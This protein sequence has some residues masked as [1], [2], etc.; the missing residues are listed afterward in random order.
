MT[1]FA[2]KRLDSYSIRSVNLCVDC[3]ISFTCNLN[4][5]I[6]I[7]KFWKVSLFFF[8]FLNGAIVITVE[9]GSIYHNSSLEKNFEASLYSYL[10]IYK[11]EQFANYDILV[12]NNHI[13]NRNMNTN[14]LIPTLR[15]INKKRHF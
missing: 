2:S 14:N 6:K 8:F 10:D 9:F 15:M 12:H 1:F 11:A 13:G 7:F 3:S 4:L 5:I